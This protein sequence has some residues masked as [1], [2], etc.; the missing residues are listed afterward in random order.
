MATYKSKYFTAEQIDD[1]LNALHSHIK[2]VNGDV[3]I[4][5]HDTANP[6]TA[7]IYVDQG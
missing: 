4:K 3:E 7:S 5:A 1:I 2:D 6:A